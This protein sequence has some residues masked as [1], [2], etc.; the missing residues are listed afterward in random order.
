MNILMLTN[1][2]TPLVGGITRSIQAVTG[3]LRSA[4]HRVLIVAPQFTSDEPPE[5]EG[6]IR[7][8]SV[9]NA[10]RHRYAW[11][12]PIPGF[13]RTTIRDFEPDVI[14]SHHPF[15]LGTAGQR[16]SVLWD[17]PLV[18]T[19]HTWYRKY[20]ETSLGASK[21][22]TELLWSLTVSY[23]DLCDVVIA[24]SQTIADVLKEGGVDR[25]IVIVPTGVDAERFA[26][27]NRQRGR[28]AEGIP[29]DAFLAGSV[30][31][32]EPEKNPQFLAP[33]VAAFLKTNPRAHF[34]L[35]GEG[36][37]AEEV[38]AAFEAA[39]VADRFHAPGTLEGQR[40]V[41]AYAAMDV[42]AFASHTETQGMVV[43][44]AM[45][46]GL[47]VVALDASGVRDVVVDRENGRLLKEE[48]ADAFVAALDGMARRDEET[49]ARMADAA[50][51]TA[52]EFSLPNCTR[53]IVEAYRTAIDHRSQLR[54][55]G[56]MAGASSMRF[57]RYQWQAWSRMLE[58]AGEALVTGKK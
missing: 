26:G 4:G 25:T 19:H 55:E 29:E 56:E 20:M 47:P 31:R 30:S 35:V 1:I 23:C 45:A 39:G 37:S 10:Y 36:N 22:A 49:C 21:L 50:R 48:D 12:L 57:L 3:E 15:L 13:L 54:E 17:I 5:E 16:Q 53:R 7:I 43:T 40:L 2:Y 44:E 9:P 38:R 51:R 32:V 27:G 8:P 52:L 24:P 11:P 34:L 42:F 18:Y 58:V 6:V 33:T 41:D 46:A 14:H 28:R